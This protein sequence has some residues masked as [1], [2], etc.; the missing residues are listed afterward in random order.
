MKGLLLK[1][2]YVVTKQLRIFLVLIPFLALMTG[3]LMS[4]FA[5]FLGAALP[6]TAIVYDERSKWNELARMMPYSKFEIVFSKY[7]LSYV[8]IFGA[9]ILSLIG[10]QTIVLLKMESS[11]NKTYIVLIAIIGALIYTAINTPIYFR[12]GSEKG[13]FIYL[14]TMVL[15]SG[16]GIVLKEIDLGV[17]VQNLNS[18]LIGCMVVAIV[19]NIGSVY[20]SAKIVRV[21]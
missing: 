19:L 13:S 3:G 6:M 20:I 7:L 14:G 5:I 10:Q 18:I 21:K 17:L 8:G 2:I 11:Y 4:A 12:F 9:F 1:D 16:S 15:A